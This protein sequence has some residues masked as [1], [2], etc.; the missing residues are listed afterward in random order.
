MHRFRIHGPLPERPLDAT[1]NG[2]AEEDDVILTDEM[3]INATECYERL[4]EYYCRNRG[5]PLNGSEQTRIMGVAVKFAM[6]LR[7]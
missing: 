4:L 6:P 2:D 3:F 5:R 1:D 7:R